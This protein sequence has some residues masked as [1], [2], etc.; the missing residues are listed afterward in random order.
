MRPRPEHRGETGDT[1]AMLD[2]LCEVGKRVGSTPRLG[3]L[4]AEVTQLTQRALDAS[5][6][7]VLLLDEE[8]RQLFFEVAEG[9][10]G[11]TLKQ[12]RLSARS[13]IAGWVAYHGKPLIINDVSR[14]RRFNKSRD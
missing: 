9:K 6:S 14:D 12:A 1:K 11:N 3:Q 2:L 4:V 13:G 10:A 5:A 8:K 7:S